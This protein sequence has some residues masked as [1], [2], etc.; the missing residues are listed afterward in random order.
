ME[1]A[2]VFRRPLSGDDALHLS[3]GNTR[4]KLVLL[5]EVA[6][7]GNVIQAT[8]HRTGAFALHLT[9]GV[10]YRVTVPVSGSV[11]VFVLLFLLAFSA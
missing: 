7:F 1:P 11:E 6:A 4:R 10:V 9:T 5:G 3:D 8:V 2:R